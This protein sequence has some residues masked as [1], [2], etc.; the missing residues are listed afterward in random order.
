MTSA[1]SRQARFQDPSVRSKARLLAQRCQPEVSCR[2]II[3]LARLRTHTAPWAAADERHLQLPVRIFLLPLQE[4]DLL[5]QLLFMELEL[6]HTAGSGRG[7]L[8]GAAS[9]PQG[10]CVGIGGWSRS[11]RA[12]Q[13]HDTVSQKV[14]AG[15]G[16]L[17]NGLRARSLEGGRCTPGVRS[18]ASAEDNKHTDGNAN[19]CHADVHA[20][21]SGH[22]CVARCAFW[23]RGYD[24]PTGG[25][26]GVGAL[27]P[28]TL[29]I[30][31]GRRRQ[32][33]C[34]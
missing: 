5:Q 9:Q 34:P 30:A 10:V 8:A 33:T 7:R 24:W 23:S 12:A 25:G 22:A 20:W 27:T 14:T 3:Q 26:G 15:C 1:R 29:R 13:Q 18:N 17:D 28:E 6:A 11:Q 16:G 2:D 19:M 31:A 21:A 4:I 32:N